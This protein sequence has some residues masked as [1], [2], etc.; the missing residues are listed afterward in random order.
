[1]LGVCRGYC[2]G[3]DMSLSGARVYMYEM[4]LVCYSRY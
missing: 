4:L 3:F 1:M 2:T